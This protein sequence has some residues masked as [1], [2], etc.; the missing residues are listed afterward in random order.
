MS[1]ILNTLKD[2]YKKYPGMKDIIKDIEN[3]IIGI[4]KDMEELIKI[5]KDHNIGS[6]YIE[7]M[8]QQT[9]NQLSNP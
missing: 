5:G 2:M 1:S 4:Q 6:S 7:T 3:N 9:I 8:V